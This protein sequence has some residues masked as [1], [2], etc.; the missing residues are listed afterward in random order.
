MSTADIRKKLALLGYDMD[1]FLGINNE[2]ELVFKAGMEYT[3]HLAGG[4]NIWN[5]Q[6]SVLF[7]NERLAFQ[8]ERA[9]QYRSLRQSGALSY[10]KVKK[11][12]DDH[13]S[14]YPERIWNEDGRFSYEVPALEGGNAAYLPDFLGNKKHQRD[15]FLFE[16]F[17]YFDSKHLAGDALSSVITV[18]SYAKANVT[19]TPYQ[20]LYVTC[21]FGSYPVQARTTRGV[22]ATLVCPVDTLNDTETYFYAAE[23]LSDIG[24]ISGLKP[25]LVDISA[26][27]KLRRLKVG[28]SDLSYENTNLKTL[29][30]GN[31]RLIQV[32]D[33]RGSVALGTGNQKSVDASG[34]TNV[35]EIYFDRT[36]VTGVVLPV[37][38]ILKKLHLPATVTNITIRNQ[39]MITEFVCAGYTN[40]NALR[41][42]NSESTAVSSLALLN[43][44]PAGCH[45]RITGFYWEAQDAQ[46]IGD[47]LDLLDTMQ[48][49]DIDGQGR[50]ISVSSC[51]NTVSG[52]IHTESLTGAEVAAFN[53]RYPY[54][55]ISADMTTSYRRYHDEDG[56]L[57]KT[58]ECH[59]GTPQEGP[60]TGMSKANSADGHYSYTFA[61]WS[62]TQGGTT[63]DADALDNVI[64][65]RDLYAVYTATVRTYTVTWKNS[66]AAVLET[67]T[68][69]PW[70]TTPTYNGQT[71]QNP[72]SG[73][74]PFTTW[75]PS[76]GPITGNT[77][78]IA[79]YTPAYNVYFYNGSTLLDTVQVLQG[80]SATY[81]GATPQK[82]GV[83][84][85]SL[86][87]FTGWSPSPTNVQGNLSVYA[88]FRQLAAAWEVPGFDASGAYAVQWHY[89][90]TMPD[91]SRGGLAASF[92]DPSPATS[93]AGSGSSPFDNI[94][95][96]SGMKRYCVI[97]GQLVPD[98]DPSF[99]E[100]TYDTV[101]YIPEF[102]YKSEKDTVKQ[103]WTWAV[104]PTALPGYT[105]HPGSG[106]YVGRYHTGGS[107]SGVYSKSG[108]NPLA[109]TSQTNFRTYSAA[110]GAGWRMLDL[111]AWSA[112]QM[113]YL[114]EF[115]NF[116]S[117]TMLG[118]GYNVG[119]VG[120]MGGT[121]D[122]AYHTLKA[123][124]AHNQ[125]RWI[126]DPFSNVRD[127]I[128]GFIGS[129]NSNCFAAANNS[130]T[131]TTTDLN[132]LGFKLPASNDISGFGYSEYAP[133]AFIP[134]ASTSNSNYTTYVC[135]QVYSGTSAYPAFVGG[136]YSAGAFC[137]LFCFSA[138]S[139]ASS[140]GAYLGSRLL[141]KP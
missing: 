61:G 112:I 89:G 55:T 30:L 124:G 100:E 105:K 25:G 44:V 139:A 31:N 120:A 65:D 45:V 14:V 122:A 41:L 132:D 35:E 99:D 20:D 92:S 102:Y 54:I 106:L 131:G 72:T 15:K 21:K 9:A 73:G 71:P 7:V 104:S 82:T 80:G 51:I 78:Y 126:E 27:T 68:N 28:D 88:Q 47:I 95:P 6:D 84:D 57:L 33:A 24:D 140:T 93:L 85:P 116:D 69:V 70:G 101:V 91:L 113:L 53:A 137:G 86:Y 90:L 109:N 32:I 1:T 17:W 77:N 23:R 108:V 62:K 133:W 130:Y 40:V 128:D 19:L 125:Y 56:T 87:Q 83:A 96:W 39:K 8:E 138:G 50:D 76:V 141:Y 48:G 135:D 121:D 97:S 67:D 34:C 29:T 129:K 26:G 52:T 118:T 60:P 134:D 58:V 2:G 12:F 66:D 42:E 136:S 111:A 81:T 114:V 18:R 22:A 75:T 64:A 3:D 38:G 103:M 119:S 74:G 107:S 115:A 79:T 98:T 13:Q 36:A 49:I 59:D 4:A 110:K 5:G 16:T 127:W 10:A 46:E 11:M 94:L 37:G 117:Q 123:S 63:P 43:L